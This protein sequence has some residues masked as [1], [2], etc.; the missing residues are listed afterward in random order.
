MKIHTQCAQIVMRRSTKQELLKA[1]LKW[2][3]L[4]ELS[5]ASTFIEPLLITAHNL[6]RI[7]FF[8]LYR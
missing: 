7:A 8:L 5:S 1:D 3:M 2:L 6:G 4:P